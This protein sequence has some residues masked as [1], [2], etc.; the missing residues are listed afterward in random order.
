M[1]CFKT[2]RNQ[3]RKSHDSILNIGVAKT[4]KKLGI[5]LKLSKGVS[6]CETAVFMDFL[7]LPHTVYQT[8]QCKLLVGSLS[9]FE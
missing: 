7:K 2:V 5:A 6:Y 9:S 3:K 4:L 8:P 1:Y